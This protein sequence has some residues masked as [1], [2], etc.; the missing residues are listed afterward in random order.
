MPKPL[1]GSRLA[2]SVASLI[3]GLRALVPVLWHRTIF[4]PL[5]YRLEISLHLYSA[6]VEPRGIHQSQRS[7]IIDHRRSRTENS[8]DLLC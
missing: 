1:A 6:L 2:R 5:V 3:S 4:V 8:I 7:L